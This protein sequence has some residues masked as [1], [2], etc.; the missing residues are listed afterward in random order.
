VTLGYDASEGRSGVVTESSFEG[1][2]FSPELED[3]RS[4]G[5]IEITDGNLIVTTRSGESVSLPLAGI[6]V[7]LGGASGKMIFCR[8]AAHEGVTIYSEA[9][10]FFDGL[11]AV[12]NDGL[13]AQL[14]TLWEKR[15][16]AKWNIA[17]WIGAGLLIIMMTYY[18]L[19]ALATAATVVIPYSVDESIGEFA[20]DQM[21]AKE[22]GGP[23]VDAPEARAAIATIIDALEKHKSL[24]DA[25]FEIRI[26][27]SEL[28][29][30]FA[31]PGGYI[32]VFTGLIEKA[33]TY[34][35]LAAVLAH[36][37]S[38]VT[39]RH[40]TTRIVQSVGVVVL[41]QLVFGD[42]GGLAGLAE[43]L[44]TMAAINGYSRDHESDADE[45]GVRMM[46]EAGIDPSGAARFFEMLKNSEGSGEL[47]QAMSWVSTHPEHGDRIA[48][49]EAQIELLGPVRERDLL[50]DWQAVQASLTKAVEVDA[51]AADSSETQEKTEDDP[52]K[53]ENTTE[54]DSV[55]E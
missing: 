13:R 29:N 3:R 20:R 49:I 23:V 1:G 44:F 25:T 52:A 8:H 34:E 11:W 53:Q 9:P 40:G 43:E 41:L 38:H 47:S 28:V 55:E 14:H 15:K 45:E 18:A 4:T 54:L 17:G 50:I 30:A 37:I 16:R 5:R 21:G 31:L 12:G 36:E 26:V 22:L 7:E 24:E 6:S 27:R 10:G 19:A 32:T 51:D 42:V 46:H 39:L 2:V 48:A 35:E 33:S